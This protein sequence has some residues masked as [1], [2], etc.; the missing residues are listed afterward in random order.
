MQETEALG[1]NFTEEKIDPG[2]IAARP[3]EVRNKTHLYRVFSDAENDW[4]RC[5]RSFGR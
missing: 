1:H 2:R 4:D 3:S 5:G